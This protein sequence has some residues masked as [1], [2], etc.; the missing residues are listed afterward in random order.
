V[1][2][3][4]L[5]LI[6]KEVPVGQPVGYGY[7]SNLV[8]TRLQYIIDTLKEAPRSMVTENKTPWCHPMLYRAR[9]PRAMQGIYSTIR[10]FQKAAVLEDYETAVVEL[11][12][13][14]RCASHVCS[15]PLQEYN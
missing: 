9:M 15:V 5:V 13:R 7:I 3:R 4:V 12:G 1:D 8:S 11:I 2:P 10:H 6:H 14:A